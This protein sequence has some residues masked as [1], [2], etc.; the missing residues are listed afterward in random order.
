MP[1][2][3]KLSIAEAHARMSAGK[4]TAVQLVEAC[5]ARVSVREPDRISKGQAAILTAAWLLFSAS[6]YAQRACEVNGQSVNPDNGSTTAGKT[7][8]MKCRNGEGGPLVREQEI[9]NGVFMGVVRHYQDGVLEREH[10][11]NEKGNR[12]GRSREFAATTGSNNPVLREETLRNSTTVGIARTWYASGQLKRVTFHNDEG[13]GEAFA[14]FAADGKLTELRC[15]ARAQLAPHA[16]DAQWCGHSGGS[17]PVTLFAADGKTRGT[18]T[19]ERG[20][21]RKSELLWPNG[22]ARQQIEAT[23][24]GGTDRQFSQEGVKRR[25]TEWIT[26]SSGEGSRRITVVD[27][28]FHDSG[29]PVR[30]R[31]WTPAERGAE[32]QLEQRWSL[33]G[34]PRDKQEFI[35]VEGR[36]GQ[37]DL[38]YHDN[39]QLSFEGVYVREGR[40]G[41][42]AVGVHK[43]YDT[44]GR[45]RS[46][47]HYDAKG[48][49][50]RERVLDEAGAVTRDDE[51][52]EDGSRKAYSR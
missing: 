40:S 5:L 44:N 37:R 47:R 21:L 11:V 36:A 16:N 46:E 27:R 31:R 45:L 23:A 22:K 17:A 8:L 12:D 15:A 34:Q 19:H 42:Q 2:A 33:N 30:E 1:E 43:S 41:Q 4:L 28:E 3:N 26:Q 20:E 10:S 38:R 18:V 39:G 49:V 50:A 7:G 51:L 9:Q 24:K 13:R 52:F 14:E 32:L 48:R 6:S 35:T 25:E 29:A